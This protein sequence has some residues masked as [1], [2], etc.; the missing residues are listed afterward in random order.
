MYQAQAFEMGLSVSETVAPLE[1][2]QISRY[3]NIE[4]R[5]LQPDDL[6][7]YPALPAIFQMPHQALPAKLRN[8]HLGRPS[9]D[10]IGPGEIA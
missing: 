7:R 6:A 2:L 4:R 3:I 8:D 10:D 5:T 1:F 9:Y